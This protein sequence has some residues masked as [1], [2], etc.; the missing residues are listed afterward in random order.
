MPLGFPLSLA[1]LLAAMGGANARGSISTL[2]KRLSLI[3]DSDRIAA[4]GLAQHELAGQRADARIDRLALGKVQDQAARFAAKFLQIHVDGGQR[5]ARGGRYDFPIVKADDRYVA[6]HID[7]PLTQ[8]IDHATGDLVIA[9]EYSIR[10]RRV[11]RPK[12][13]NGLMPPGL[14]PGSVQ[15]LPPCPATARKASA[16]AVTEANV[17]GPVT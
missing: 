5:R 6:R 15:D 7:T 16:R 12:P 8:G 4:T 14:G 13:V 1:A 17:S 3:A 10:T 11:A 9:A 2:L